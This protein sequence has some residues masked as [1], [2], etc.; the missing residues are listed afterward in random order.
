MSTQQT[1][2][3]LLEENAEFLRRLALALLGRRD[4]V[5]DVLQE[6]SVAALR[7]E[8]VAVER[9]RP[10]LTVVLKNAAR[11]MW[12]TQ[13]RQG[14]RQ[15]ARAKLDEGRVASDAPSF[16]EQLEMA[17]R[18]HDAVD[19][20]P[21]SQ[22]EAITLRYYQGLKPGAIAD[23]LVTPVET[24]R[25]R[26]KRGLSNLRARLGEDDERWRGRLLLLAAPGTLGAA[27]DAGV[28]TATT[29]AATVAWWSV[30][31]AAVLVVGAAAGAWAVLSNGSAP[32]EGQDA[33]STALA[34]AGEADEAPA[35][36]P[37]PWEGFPEPDPPADV[38]E[39]AT[40]VPGA[41]LVAEERN[42]SKWAG[43]D[44]E[45]KALVRAMRLYLDPDEDLWRGRI[46]VREA[47]AKQRK[48]G[49]DLLADM[50][51]LR[52][53]IY[54]ARGFH[55][56]FNDRSYL[57]DT[58]GKLKKEGSA[59]HIRSDEL[60]IG[61]VT[62]KSY[63]KKNKAFA[64][65]KRPKEYPLLVSTIEKRDQNEN[66]QW[67]AFALL[68][69]RYP[70]KKKE[71]WGTFQNE[72]LTLVPV[73]SAGRYID[74]EGRLETSKIFYPINQFCRR[75][76]VDFDR[77]VFDGG[78][79]ALTV[80]C[81]D[82]YMFAG[83]VLRKAEIKTDVDRELV[84][85]A[86][87]LPLFVHSN[88][89]LAEDL[90]AAGHPLVTT[91][92]DDELK[93]WLGARGRTIPKKFTWQIATPAHTFAHWMTFEE[94]M[95]AAQKR[96]VNVEVLATE[97]NPNTIK[98]ESI[99]VRR[100]SLFLNDEIVDLGRK[101]RVVINGHLMKDERPTRDFDVTFYRDPLNL[102]KSM[103]FSLLFPVRMP[104]IAVKAPKP[105]EKAPDEPMEPEAVQVK[106]AKYLAAAKKLI[107]AG[108]FKAARQRLLACIDLG[109]T[110]SRNEA[111]AL[112]KEIKDK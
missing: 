6:V 26:I 50:P 96:E 62:P 16:V 95:W 73:A 38:D 25:T 75:Y 35:P 60:L 22:R 83:V 67:P 77:I 66:P 19:Q 27:Q 49:Y 110:P 80:A 10:W 74:K 9:G 70:S 92:G 106:A 58:E 54:E 91:G 29:A 85:N 63:P 51:T 46:P 7:N 31:V 17:R 41:P 87:H 3:H 24:I 59:T 105:V 112:L 8:R 12:R 21:E 90:K 53:L 36:D 42:A 5:E 61:W 14:M 11:K 18:L 107:A 86:Q 109:N 71:H 23:R 20:L 94:V 1:A 48:R 64:K 45:W 4:G 93:T 78:Q 88:D 79:E 111:R 104:R 108:K 81:K 56:Q 69:R 99:G 34:A 43:T 33:R 44:E 15:L 40:P 47:L 37:G 98:I 82:T 102:R 89:K 52:R 68:S 55:A 57:R 32:G 97:E 30:P 39:P 65:G 84:V 76:H 100:L 72:W 101:V 13:K 103:M 28:A 2:S